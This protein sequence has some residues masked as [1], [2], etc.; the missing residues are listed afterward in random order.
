MNSK[1][2]ELQ[3][4]AA[5]VMHCGLNDL[6]STTT[7]TIISKA[8][9]MVATIHQAREL[10]PQSKIIISEVAPVKDQHLD[11][12]RRIYNAHLADSI[13][14]YK[15]VYISQNDGLNPTIAAMRDDTHPSQK[16]TGILAGFLGRKVRGCIWMQNKRRYPR[17]FS[18]T[19]NYDHQTF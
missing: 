1:Q 2:P 15:D 13:I 6:R 8:E 16:G 5:I 4:P 9:E 10:F 18:R 12:K 7:P 3:D 14:D 19:K 11:N 17:H